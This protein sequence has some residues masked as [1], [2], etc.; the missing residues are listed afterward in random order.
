MAETNQGYTLQ[1][2]VTTFRSDFGSCVFTSLQLQRLCRVE[3][4]LRMVTTGDHHDYDMASALIIYSRAGQLHPTR[5][6]HNSLK[7]CLSAA[8]VYTYI[9]NREGIE[10]TNSLQTIRHSK[11]AVE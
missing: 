5:W 6:P 2:S 4:V 8:V 7:A 1:Y 10:F 11:S 3:H 9:S